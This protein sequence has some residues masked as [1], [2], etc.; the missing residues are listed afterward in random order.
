MMAFFVAM[1]E[2]KNSTDKHLN[3]KAIYRVILQ[4]CLV[5]TPIPELTY[6]MAFSLSINIE[7]VLSLN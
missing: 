5:G 4:Q 6:S 2:L 1:S 7:P 3:S